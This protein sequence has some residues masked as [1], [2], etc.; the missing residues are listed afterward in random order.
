MGVIVID[1]TAPDGLGI[2]T[3]E[4]PLKR[5]CPA[6][7]TALAADLVVGVDAILVVRVVIFLVPLLKLGCQGCA[8]LGVFSNLPDFIVAHQLVHES[9]DDLCS[10]VCWRGLGWECEREG[11][12]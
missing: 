4:G 11:G 7:A 3:R 10:F 6:D 8:A 9:H 1:F 2:L 5:F 12:M